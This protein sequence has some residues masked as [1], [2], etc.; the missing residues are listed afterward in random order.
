MGSAVMVNTLGSTIRELRKQKGLSVP[1]L[2]A[3]ISLSQSYLYDLEHDR[4]VPSVPILQRLAAFFGVTT[5]EL[6]STEYKNAPTDVAGEGDGTRRIIS[7]EDWIKVPVV[8]REWTACCGA[9]ITAEDIT[10]WDDGIIL[11]PRTE[12]HRF[13]DMRRPFAVH[14]EGDC[15]ESAGIFDGDLAV[16]NPAE[17][18]VQGAIVLV[19]LGGSLSLKRYYSMPNGDVVLQS[20]HGKT[21][22]TPEQMERDEFFVCGVLAGTHRGRPKALPL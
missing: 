7:M 15:M 3:Q 9:G 1:K 22:L 18:P 17:E 2:A 14:C 20:D 19:T 13:D 5:D 12:L 21:R 16:V 10:S 8:S 11:F 4:R 6:M